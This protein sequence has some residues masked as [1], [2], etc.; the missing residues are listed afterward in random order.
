MSLGHKHRHVELSATCLARCV[1]DTLTEEPTL[2]AVTIDT[3]QQKISLA[4][5]GRVDVEKLTQKIS[6]KIQSAQ[7]S[8]A[9]ET[10]SLFKGKSDC[11]TC[12]QPLSES[13]LK[14]I[15][16]RRDATATTTRARTAS[17][18]AAGRGALM[19]G[20]SAASERS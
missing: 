14:R 10:C 1:A 19:A 17:R 16:I 5:L 8:S 4:T 20:P 13:E 2:E 11:G 9:S 3:A 6:A 15:I 18:S 12:S 7:N